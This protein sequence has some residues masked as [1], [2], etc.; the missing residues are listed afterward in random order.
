ME[1]LRDNLWIWGHD[2]GCHHSGAGL[3]WKIPGTNK[4][5]PVEGAE[6]LGI[7]NCCRV[8]FEGNPKPPFDAESEKLRSFNKVVW[9]VIGDTSSSRN[10]DGADDLDD[11]LRQAELFPNVTGGILDD[12]FRLE[13]KDARMTPERLQ[14][15]ADKL[16]ASPRPLELWLVYYAAL[17][18]ADYSKYLEKV[19]V[20]SF[21]SWDSKQLAQ[22][23]E[24]LEKIISMTPGKK[25]YAGCYLY[26]YGDCCELTDDEMNFQ[27]DLYLKFWKE[28]KIDG[29]IVCSNNIADTGVH[30]VDIFRDWNAR[31]GGE[32]R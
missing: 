3:Q 8:V 17:F 13:T 4:M 6:Y 32:T 21:W 29:I 16:H 23:E 2:A 30:A 1:T 28:K 25:H 5:G 12:F 7:P 24:N 11:V 14:E 10:N 9:S 20:V 26:N 31:H 18:E 22:A 19:D 15:V 27:L